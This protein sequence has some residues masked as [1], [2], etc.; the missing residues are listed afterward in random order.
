MSSTYKLSS[1]RHEACEFSKEYLIPDRV[2]TG[3]AA[4]FSVSEHLSNSIIV[5]TWVAYPTIFGKPNSIPI[6]V[7]TTP[8][9]LYVAEHACLH[10]SLKHLTRP[11]LQNLLLKLWT[12]ANS[13]SALVWRGVDGRLQK[14]ANEV[15]LP[16]HYASWLDL[17]RV[18]G[19]ILEFDNNINLWGDL[20]ETALQAVASQ[21]SIETAQ[22]LLDPAAT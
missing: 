16:V 17:E 2:K 18:V 20:L 9:Y 19:Y 13:D 4:Q 7:A 14:P 21:G 15:A 5:Q 1:R 3:T 22:S 12:P 6:P 10:L 8:L 11:A